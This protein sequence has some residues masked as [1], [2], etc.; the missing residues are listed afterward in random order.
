MALPSLAT[1]HHSSVLMLSC[2]KAQQTQSRCG[3][4]IRSVSSTSGTRQGCTLPALK[5]DVENQRSG[6]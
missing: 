5:K 2:Q 1:L 4:R 3:A 6:M